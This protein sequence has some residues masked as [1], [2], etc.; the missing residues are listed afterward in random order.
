MVLNC[1]EGY[2]CHGRMFF[3][4]GR[5]GA[6]NGDREEGDD[7]FLK[8]KEQDQELQAE[9]KQNPPSL[10]SL[11][12][13][14][15]PSLSFPCSPCLSYLQLQHYPTKGKRKRPWRGFRTRERRPAFSAPQLGCR[16][17]EGCP[18]TQGRGTPGSRRA[19]VGGGSEEGPE[20]K[21]V[22]CLFWG[23]KSQPVSPPADR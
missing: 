14:L 2:G 1:W 6:E 19:R 23:R 5:C 18:K 17:P 7:A 21:L 20:T 15:P 16:V 10:S 22:V 4:T 9:S 11:P 13:P 8:G 3:I 12:P